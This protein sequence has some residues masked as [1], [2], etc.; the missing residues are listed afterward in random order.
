LRPE[1]VRKGDDILII[2]PSTGV[3]EHNV[4][5][6]RTNLESVDVAVKGEYCSLPVPPGTKLRR[7]DK[8]YLW[9]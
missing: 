6:I 3:M 7:S 5:E 4:D 2:G 8:L 9:R 1:S